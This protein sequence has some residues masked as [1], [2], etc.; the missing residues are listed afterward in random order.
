MKKI[1]FII[2]L[3][4]TV[5]HL[6]SYA[7]DIQLENT[8]LQKLNDAPNDSTK[9]KILYRLTNVTKENPEKSNYYI[10]ALLKEAENQKNNLYKCRA[11]L[12][13]I[14]T[15]GNMYDLQEVNKWV[16]LLEPLARK[17]KKYDLMFQGKRVAIDL[18]NLEGQFE[19]V[20]KEAYKMLKEAQ[21]LQSNLGIGYAYQSLGYVNAYTFRNEEAAE[22]FEEAYTVFSHTKS[23]S[24]MLEICDRLVDI[25]SILKNNPKR[26]EA[27]RKQQDITQK[28]YKTSRNNLLINYLHF[29]NYY[30]DANN[31]EE[32]KK[33]MSYTEKN[34]TKG[35]STHEQIYRTARCNY[36]HK[37]QNFAQAIAEIDTMLTTSPNAQDSNECYFKKAALLKEMGRAQDALDLYKNIWPTKVSLHIT[38]L[39][40]QVKQVK[41]DYDAETLLL[42]KE[43]I[44]HITQVS[45]ILLIILVAIVLIIF[46]IHT[47]RIQRTLSAAEK[48]QK[49]LNNETEQASMIKERFMTNIST[50]IS[51]PLN[52]VLKDSLAL[53]SDEALSP[54]KRIAISGT[55]TNTS[56]QLMKLINNVLDLSRLE[57]KMMKYNIIDAEMTSTLKN[58]IAIAI[59]N[60]SHIIDEIAQ[61]NLVWTKIDCNRL[62]Q[63]IKSIIENV[64]SDDKPIIF[65]TEVLNGDKIKITVK[66]SLL[67][68]TNPAQD[69]VIY[70]EINNMIINNFNGV[71]E[72][73]PEKEEINILLSISNLQKI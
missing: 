64:S 49:K 72:V 1:I 24:S 38:T 36:F 41:K 28:Y 7:Y 55:I 40:E 10:N 26:L 27:I 66:G 59:A 34:F 60:G 57:A 58:I 61:E 9:L 53:A 6:T 31:L 15:A 35:F 16:S 68:T 46:M 51:L 52:R 8:L 23:R 14:V 73:H 17:E 47:Y 4:T 71:Y 65:R 5:C 39:N 18:L 37:T 67:S 43:E 69:I 20:E 25:Y 2:C 42:K 32:A 30:L 48:E 29:L 11:Y 44:Q 3:L 50:A 33:Y 19:L 56:N 70:N 13:Y 21:E 54:E 63:V 45:F 62:A 22:F 12:L